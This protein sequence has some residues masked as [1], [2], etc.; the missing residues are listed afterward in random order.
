MLVEIQLLNFFTRNFSKK[1]SQ[2]SDH[3]LLIIISMFTKKLYNLMYKNALFLRMNATNLIG[4]YG[5]FGFVWNSTTAIFTR[6][7]KLICLYS[8]YNRSEIIVFSKN[9]EKLNFLN[10][11]PETYFVRFSSKSRTHIGGHVENIS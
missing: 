11:Y 4:N 6:I 2:T 10:T 8:H 9:R 7:I 1:K 3:L 5:K